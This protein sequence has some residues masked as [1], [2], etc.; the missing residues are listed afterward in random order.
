MSIHHFLFFYSFFAPI[1]FLLIVLFLFW[2]LVHIQ[3]IPELKH[4]APGV[5]IV[6]VGTK[7]GE[8][9][10]LKVHKLQVLMMILC[11]LVLGIIMI[12][13]FRA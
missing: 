11:L 2:P 5:P 4:Y 6:L 13:F 3:W 1:C 9:S 10:N 8:I 7:L 12:D